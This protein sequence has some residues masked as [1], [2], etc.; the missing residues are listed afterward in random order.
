MFRKHFLLR[1]AVMLTAAG[2]LSRIMGFF[3][4]IFLSR[5]FGEE[6]VG[7]YQL[8]FPVYAL[9]LSVSTSG[10]QTALSR[11]TAA[12]VSLGKT[13]E[14]QNALFIALGLTLFLSFIQIILV[15]QNADFIASS[16]LGDVRCAEMLLIISYALP[17]A[18]IHGCICGYSL[19]IQHTGLAAVSQLIEQT[20]RIL[21]VILLFIFFQKSDY[22]PS[23]RLAAAG[24]VAGELAAAIFST[25][26]LKYA[27][28]QILPQPHNSHINRLRNIKYSTSQI[29]NT[30]K[31]LLSLSL[32]LTANRVTVTLLQSIEAASIPACLKLYGMNTA[33]SLSLYGVL[34]GMAL[35]CILFP[36]AITGSLG[37]VLMPAISAAQASG[38]S[39][40]II[41][42]LKKTVMSC[43]ILGFSCC[44]FFLIFGNMIGSILFHSNSASKFIIT[45]AWICP[46]LYTNTCLL[47]ALNGLGK[48]TVNFL[49]NTSGLLVRIV[50]VFFA[51]PAFGITGYLHSLLL[52]QLAVSILSGTALF[53]TVRK[54]TLLQKQD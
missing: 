16:F 39:S 20:V 37:T 29:N 49:I 11:I 8:V 19:G 3:F 32:P 54:E 44:L 30:A 31:Q 2:I 21:F 50:G 1:G 46:F 35:P 40:S 17:C 14:A 53:I 23:V 34:T 43:L 45:L 47:S 25:K 33:D 22:I 5:A 26:R 24:I 18:A 41:S 13:K 28:T 10:L 4:R 12:K 9:C 38:S 36:S 6:N 15:Q 42:L 52:S 51:I 27:N 7:L 48:T